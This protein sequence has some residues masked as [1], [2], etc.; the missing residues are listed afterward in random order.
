MASYCKHTGGSNRN[1]RL[2]RVEE[3]RQTAETS[4]TRIFSFRILV[5][6]DS[7][8]NITTS[9]FTTLSKLIQICYY[10][11]LC[12]GRSFLPSSLYL[13]RVQTI[14]LASFYLHVWHI[15][16]EVSIVYILFNPGFFSLNMKIPSSF[17]PR[18]D[19]YS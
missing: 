10:T 3:V 19:V 11:H 8:F 17:N 9:F 2:G 15:V 7:V 6:Y 18:R 12:T 16:V 1:Y 13:D 5:V 14:S 4:G